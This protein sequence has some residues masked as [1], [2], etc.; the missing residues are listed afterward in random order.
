M[1]SSSVDL[2]WI[3][4]SFPS[5][6]FGGSICPTRRVTRV[7]AILAF[8]EG[9]TLLLKTSTATGPSLIHNISR[10]S[11]RGRWGIEYPSLSVCTCMCMA[12]QL[13]NYTPTMALAT[14]CDCHSYVGALRDSIPMFT[15][16]NKWKFCICVAVWP[17]VSV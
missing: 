5:S 3:F 1:T 7:A 6:R 16:F 17:C 10:P 8:V 9:C 4:C 12:N 2:R 15:A 11:Y 14:N 13:G